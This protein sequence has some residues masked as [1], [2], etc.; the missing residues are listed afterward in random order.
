[1]DAAA[2]A[3]AGASAPPAPPAPA[4]PVIVLMPAQIAA[5]ATAAIAATPAFAAPVEKFSENLFT[6]PINPSTRAGRKLCNQAM[7][8]IPLD[9]YLD[10]M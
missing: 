9:K 6:E 2:A 8:T 3:A 5:I 7:K 1:M 4:P 10:I